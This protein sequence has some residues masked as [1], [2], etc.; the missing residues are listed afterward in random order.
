VIKAILADTKTATT[1]LPALHECAGEPSPAAGH[2]FR[3]PQ[4]QRNGARG[5]KESPSACRSSAVA[6]VMSS[7][8]CFK[9]SK[10]E[11]R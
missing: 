5:K 8:C 1:G 9:M 4:R 10:P 7:G 2:R 11:L 3:V 6:R